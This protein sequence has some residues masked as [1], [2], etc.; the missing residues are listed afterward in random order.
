MNKTWE[1]IAQEQSITLLKQQATITRL[2]KQIEDTIGWAYG[3]MQ[4][5][6]NDKDDFAKISVSFLDFKIL[7]QVLGDP[8]FIV[9]IK[10]RKEDG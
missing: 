6:K 3:E 4:V 7:L 8:A 1:Q 10:G 9:V 5:F 2:E